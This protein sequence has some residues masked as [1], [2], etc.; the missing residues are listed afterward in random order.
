VIEYR[1]GFGEQHN[2]QKRS[3]S[4][5]GSRHRLFSAATLTAAAAVGDAARLLLRRCRAGGIRETRVWLMGSS[6]E[7]VRHAAEYIVNM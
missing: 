2:S 1:G 5:A 6:F 7:G 3:H 4:D